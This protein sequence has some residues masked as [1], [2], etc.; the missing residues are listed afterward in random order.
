MKR[1]ITT[2]LCSLLLFGLFA[3]SNKSSGKKEADSSKTNFEKIAAEAKSVNGNRGDIW[4]KDV[5]SSGETY[6]STNFYASSAFLTS[7]ESSSS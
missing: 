3:K 1:V 2:L 7:S 4:V 6:S 5:I